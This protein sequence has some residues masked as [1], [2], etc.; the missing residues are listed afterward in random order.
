[1]GD[2]PASSTPATIDQ[3]LTNPGII[4]ACPECTRCYRPAPPGYKC[5]E[6]GCPCDLHAIILGRQAKSLASPRTLIFE[7]LSN[8]LA[9]E[10]MVCCYFADI[11]RG[12]DVGIPPFTGCF[13]HNLAENRV[14]RH[15]DWIA[16]LY[17]DNL[18]GT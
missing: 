12:G 13:A 2:V 18:S 14:F 6:P 17:N 3:R 8:E 15:S 11:P 9:C 5:S 10:A 16:P 7:E 4:W 1:M